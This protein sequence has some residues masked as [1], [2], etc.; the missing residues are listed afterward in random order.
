MRGSC[1]TVYIR[2]WELLPGAAYFYGT[3]VEYSHTRVAH[4]REVADVTQDTVAR[5]GIFYIMHT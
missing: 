4:R 1:S 5:A 2:P 3:G